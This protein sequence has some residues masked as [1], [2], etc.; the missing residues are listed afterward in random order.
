M[1]SLIAVEENEPRRKIV[2]QWMALPQD[3]RRAEEQVATFA[4]PRM[5]L[6]SSTVPVPA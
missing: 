2:R 4:N 1:K 3:K 5:V 6:S